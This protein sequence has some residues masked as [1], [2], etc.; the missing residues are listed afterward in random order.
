MIT[1]YH[2]PF[3]RSGG[4][5]WLL[6]EIGAD[7]D[8][9]YV[10]IL[11]G[12][13]SGSLDKRNPHPHGKVPALDIDGELLFE[14]VAICLYLTEK[15]PAAKL[16]PAPGQRGRAEFL[17][18]LA[19]YAGVIEPAFTS[20]FM[21]VTPPRGT[22]GWVAVEEVMPFIHAQLEKHAYIAGND[23]TA[24]D[25]LYAG[26]FAL[27]MNSPLMADYKNQTMQDYVARCVARPAYARAQARDKAK[28]AA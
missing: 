19:Y 11:R 23:F 10:D 17:S 2:A 28:G 15:F 16:A 1:L 4:A 3:S 18:M 12:D 25:I 14:R 13:G 26:A 22:A 24:A 7:Y 9:R 21:K 27:F 6:E 5:V 8:I 20:K